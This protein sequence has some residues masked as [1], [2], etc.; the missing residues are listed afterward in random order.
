M[1]HYAFNFTVLIKREPKKTDTASII[2]RFFY[3]FFEQESE[4]TFKI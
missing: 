1:K 4:I 2:S 3:I